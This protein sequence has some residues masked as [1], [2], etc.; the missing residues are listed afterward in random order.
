M[1]GL[2]KYGIELANATDS[3]GLEM[4]IR[5]TAFQRCKAA[6]AAVEGEA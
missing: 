6:R 2:Y 1:V 5:A 4:M 3:Q